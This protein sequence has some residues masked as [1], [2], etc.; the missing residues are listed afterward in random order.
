MM[1]LLLDMV[2]LDV[3]L[4]TGYLYKIKRK[5]IL[6]AFTALGTLAIFREVIN[7]IF[8]VD[9]QLYHAIAAI[10]TEKATCR[11]IRPIAFS[12]V[13]PKFTCDAH[14]DEFPSGYRQSTL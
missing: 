1:V 8:T 6:A 9:V 2:A 13:L 7:L 14:A 12:V 5:N 11:N 3:L 10:T 4:N